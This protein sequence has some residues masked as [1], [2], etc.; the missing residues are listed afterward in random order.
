VGNLRIAQI[1]PPSRRP[2][3]ISCAQFP[4]FSSAFG[5]TRKTTPE[6]LS[7][8]CLGGEC[9]PLVSRFTRGRARA[10]LD[11]TP[12]APAR[13]ALQETVPAFSSAFPPDYQPE[14]Q[15][16]TQTGQTFTPA[17]QREKDDSRRST[18]QHLVQDS[19]DQQG[20]QAPAST[21]VEIASLSTAG[22]QRG[23]LVQLTSGVTV[24]DIVRDTYGSYTVLAFDLVRE[25]NPHITDLGRTVT[26]ETLWF[27]PLAE[28]TLMRRQP[29]GSYVLVL[30]SFFSLADA[31][32]YV[33]AVQADDYTA[34]ILPQ[35]IPANRM[36]Y[37]VQLQGLQTQKEAQKAWKLF[38]SQTT[39]SAT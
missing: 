6:I 3:R 15:R 29:D 39:M 28:D 38:S 34:K 23:G 24:S 19:Q 20:S 17:Q 9:T 5:S 12:A 32:R 8:E 1:A 33:R 2:S 30:K 7:D 22:S 11:G 21:P 10:L 4:V 16:L 37:R 14:D 25:F 36:L 18:I 27:P 26:G 31:Q 35:D 13:A